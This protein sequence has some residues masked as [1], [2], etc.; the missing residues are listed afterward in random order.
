MPDASAVTPEYLPGGIH[1]PLWRSGAVT[2]QLGP[3]ET[4]ASL[5]PQGLVR[6]GVC[7][8]LSQAPAPSRLLSHGTV[9]CAL[10]SERAR[11]WPRKRWHCRRPPYPAGDLKTGWRREPWRGS[12]RVHGSCLQDKAILTLPPIDGKSGYGRRAVSCGWR[13]L[14]GAGHVVVAAKGEGSP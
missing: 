9:C 7:A 2:Q 14:P 10:D 6:L 8:V 11:A 4:I 3:D 13:T 5:S 1:L 12:S